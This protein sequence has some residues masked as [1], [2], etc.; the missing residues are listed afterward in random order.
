[1]FCLGCPPLFPAW[2]EDGCAAH[3]VLPDMTAGSEL[4]L[5][6]S[7]VTLMMTVLDT[8]EGQ[9]LLETKLLHFQELVT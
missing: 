1:V 9:A 5:G 8:E 2:Q 7:C 6:S 4:A 3:Q